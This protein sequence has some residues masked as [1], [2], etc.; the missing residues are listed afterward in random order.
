MQLLQIHPE[1]QI[2]TPRTRATQ[3]RCGIPHPIAFL[4][5]TP[6]IY[7]PDSMDRFSYSSS[8]EFR[9]PPLSNPLFRTFTGVPG[10]LISFS[11]LHFLFEQI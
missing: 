1:A 9:T 10:C 4:N 2:K 6:G 7:F 5:S 8:A 11:A 3:V